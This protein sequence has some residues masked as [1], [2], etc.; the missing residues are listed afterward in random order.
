VTTTG[1]PAVGP[2]EALVAGQPIPFGGDR[3]AV[4][5][6]ELA[7]AF[8]P[9]DRLVVVQDTGALLHIPRAEHE[10]A[11]RAVADAVA[12]FAALADRPDEAI[13]CFFDA[14]ARHLAD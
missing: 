3:V 5:S 4:V 10:L 1:T 13:T 6:A 8:R 14:F 9:G 11:A 7:G 2:L 12:G